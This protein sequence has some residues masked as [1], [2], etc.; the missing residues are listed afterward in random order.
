[1]VA[2]V[3]IAAVV[4]APAPA[5]ALRA[6]VANGPVV[7]LHWRDRSRRETRWEVRRGGGRR[8]VLK[9]DTTAWTD[10]TVRVGHTYAYRVRPCRRSRCA[11]WRLVRVRLRVQPLGGPIPGPS[12]G[13]PPPG[14]PRAPPAVARSPTVAGCPPVPED[15]PGD[16]D[17]SAAPG[18]SPS[19]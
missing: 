6:T 17:P 10:H 2:A 5:T 1:M 4:G 19:S 9:R 8:H 7:R 12:P 14:A 11:R 15:N 3:L 13:T 16:T 18:R